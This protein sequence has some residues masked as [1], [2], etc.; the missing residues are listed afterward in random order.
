MCPE[1]LRTDSRL[2]CQE[3]TEPGV[4]WSGSRGQRSGRARD[5]L[6]LIGLWK[7]WL[8]LCVRWEAI[9]ASEQRS[10]PFSCH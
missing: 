2:G 6:G 10:H 4:G 1:H 9:E 7:D 3:W 5:T 8:L